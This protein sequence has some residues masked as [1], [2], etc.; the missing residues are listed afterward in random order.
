MTEEYTGSIGYNSTMN[1]NSEITMTE[2]VELATLDAFGLLPPVDAVRFE[3]AFM[4]APAD[5]QSELRRLQSNFAEN[6]LLLPDE[7]PDAALRQRVLA[8]VSHT[9]E[10]ESDRL[11]P[12]ATIGQTANVDA[13]D[14]HF[15]ATDTGATM[16]NATLR[17]HA[18]VWTWRMAALILLGVTISLAIFGSDAY[19]QSKLLANAY[20]GK[21]TID[22]IEEQVGPQFT[23]FVA[24]P[25]C[26]MHYMV[27]TNGIGM[28]RVAVNERTGEAFVLGLDL[29]PAIGLGELRL[30]DKQGNAHAIAM[31]GSDEPVTGQFI[32]SLDMQLFAADTFDRL[33]LVDVNGAVVMRSV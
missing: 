19:R 8:A 4:A 16:P 2:L 3:R 13:V 6:E 20:I 10:V 21:V 11:A 15:D 12:L 30:V 33:E 17:S 5:V 24:N 1:M 22:T 31:I 7:E 32:Q 14:A 9:I 28:I 27:S 25:N 29:D 23:E 26:H 18:S